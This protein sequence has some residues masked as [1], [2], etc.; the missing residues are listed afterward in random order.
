MRLG[1]F[2]TNGAVFLLWVLACLPLSGA[3]QQEVE[4]LDSDPLARK[5]RTDSTE[6]DSLL[7]AS[8]A[9]RF[10]NQDSSITLARKAITLS[11]DIDYETGK[12]LGFKNIGLVYS[13]RNNFTEALDFFNRSLIVYQK[14]KDTTGISSIQNNI[15]A[16]YQ[17]TGNDPKA[18]EF[19]FESLKNAEIVQD[20]T[21]IGTAYVNI[22][23]VYSNDELTYDQAIENYR[24][25]IPYFEEIDYT[26]GLAVAN[27]N[28]GE[29]Y[30]KMEQPEPS[31][32][33][34]R[35]AL[36]GFREIGIDPATPLNFLGEAYLK[37][38]EYARAE[39]YYQEALASSIDKGTRSE[40]AKANLGLGNVGLE[41]RKTSTSLGYFNRALEIAIAEE[42]E[43]LREKNDAYKGLSEAYAM[44]GDYRN[45]FVAQ[46]NYAEV[47]DSI[48]QSDY[49][50][51]MSQLRTVFDLEQKE[52]EIALL[53]AEND[54]N[55]LQIEE[56]ARQRQLL[57]IIIGLFIAII[58]G[59]VFQFFYIRRTNKRLAFERNRSDQILLN[60]L[61]RETA[62]ELKEQGFVKAREF[63]EITV[64]FTD[65][66]AF[67]LIAER[68]SADRLVK[69]VDYYFKSFD[70]ITE[71]HALEKIK[72][73]GDAYMCAGGLP[74]PNQ[75]HVQDAFRA[76]VE[77]L[78]FVRETELNP[79]PGIY[80]FKIRIGLNSGPVVAGVVGTKKFAYDIWGNTVN[81]AARME[82][83]S[84][85]G[86]INVSENIYQ[87]LKDAYDF[88]YRGELEVKNQVFKMYFAEVPETTTT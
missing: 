32:P 71:R 61:P 53:N 70:E 27:V 75:T 67:S 47:S 21:R 5:I 64:L 14:E 19:F 59:F 43:L 52:K 17:T 31:L 51:E 42:P 87:E 22:G 30:L 74:T 40:E 56:D 81:I 48:R 35:D 78:N 29:L 39:A 66:K 9:L 82:S 41:L 69:S 15:G 50:N 83:G 76:A 77:I 68:I 10:K 85:P 54:L 13:D 12:A 23:T 3:A 16:V 80:P 24:K 36:E 57:L 7:K 8:E 11:D 6:V 33:F 65:F 73:I 62:D 34:L 37:M 60:I 46:K 20:P 26:L 49:A 63:E 44:Q 88:T 4:K 86:R 55:E 72:T 18:L 84:V 79:P 45:A 38:K 58:A 1:G 2:G 25:S 28:I